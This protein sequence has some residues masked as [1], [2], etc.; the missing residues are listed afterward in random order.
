MRSAV[1]LPQRSKIGSVVA[2][3]NY[4][5]VRIEG[6]VTRG[7]IYDVDAQSLRFY[8]TDDTGEIQATTFRDVTEQLVAKNQ[9]P[10]TGDKISVEGTLRIRD[11]F[12]SL[13]VASA[14]NLH[15]RPPSPVEINIGE[16]GQDDEWHLPRSRRRAR[17]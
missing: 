9:V 14:T 10:A 1:H 5:Y 11:D 15:S 6:L 3:T 4:A 2:T 8:I 13:N 17:D 7:P 16:I 12:N